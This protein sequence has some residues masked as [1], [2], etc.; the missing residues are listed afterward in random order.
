M[1]DAAPSRDGRSARSAGCAGCHSPPARADDTRPSMLKDRSPPVTRRILVTG[2]AGFIGSALCTY[3]VQERGYHVV[4]VDKLTYAGDLAS[5]QSIADR[6]TYRFVRADIADSEVIATVLREERIDSVMHLAAETHVDRS[7]ASPAE[8]IDTNI[9]GTFRLLETVL[10]YWRG[11]DDAPKAG[12]RFHYVSTDEVF[13]DASDNDHKRRGSRLTH[14]RPSSPYSASKAAA[15]HL[16]NAWH[17]TYG[18]PVLVSNS[19]NTYGPFQLPDKFVPLMIRRALDQRP[20]PIYGDGAHVRDWLYVDDHVRALERVLVRGR[21]GES[22]PIGQHGTRSNLEVARSICRLLDQ[23][24]PRPGGA[25]HEALIT[26]VPDRPGHDR[27]YSID[28]RKAQSELDW[29]PL[30]TFESG[31]ARTV[32]WHLARADR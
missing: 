10:S 29:R 20:L 4:N 26:F 27:R 30:D 21:V 1:L 12:F 22:Y 28:L 5:L 15:E 18:L 14:Y 2:G 25:L 3:L 11:L 7:I 17:R 6:A 16:A 31:L 9:L 19:S 23:R 8:F 32:D 13:G 24:R